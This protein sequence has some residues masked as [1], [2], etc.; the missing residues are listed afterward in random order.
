MHVTAITSLYSKRSFTHICWCLFKHK[1]HCSCSSCNYNS[2]F[3][4][5]IG[6]FQNGFISQW[7]SNGHLELLVCI[8]PACPKN[9]TMLLL[10]INFNNI[11]DVIEEKKIDKSVS[12]W[13]N[14]FEWF[15]KVVTFRLGILESSIF[16]TLLSTSY[17]GT[18]SLLLV[19][20][21]SNQLH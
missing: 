6:P 8:Q 9:S 1:V 18:M 14:S 10:K 5:H 12:F 3:L 15:W 11:S 16:S 19:Y 17:M 13:K 20:S 7:P 21:I 4:C 2:I